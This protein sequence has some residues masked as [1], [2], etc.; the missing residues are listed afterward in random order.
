MTIRSTRQRLYFDA[1][2]PADFERLCLWLVELE[3]YSDVEHLGQAGGDDGCDVIGW[4]DKVRI[5]FQC[6]RVRA[7][8][9]TAIQKE[10]EKVL[11][12][13]EGEIPGELIFVAPT[14]V[15]ANARRTARETAGETLKIGFW[16]GTELDRKVK[17]HPELLDE[18]FR[19]EDSKSLWTVQQARNPF[20]TG[21]DQVLNELRQRLQD[22]GSAALTQGITGLGGI[23]KTQLADHLST[24]T[25]GT[26]TLENVAQELQHLQDPNQREEVEMFLRGAGVPE[27]L[28]QALAAMLEKPS[29]FYSAFISYSHA[30]KAFA[31]RLYTDLQA[32]GVRCWLD[33]HQLLPGDSVADSIDRGIRLWDKVLLC[34]SF[35]ALTSWWV[36]DEIDK[37]LEKERKL[38][39]DRKEKVLAIIPIIL[40]GSLFDWEDGNASTL[41]KRL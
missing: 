32:R 27:V 20:F 41:R 30:N 33:E 40:D 7:L 29:K 4:R 9:P 31:R 11:G 36:G 24:S 1:L 39:K 14:S 12:L 26:D 23:G 22:S 16:T 18:F 3:G 25:I 2:S 13:P 21:R 15:S 6:K 35:E 38:L 8:G 34:C 19:E 17:K 5:A 10:V 37:A 28:M